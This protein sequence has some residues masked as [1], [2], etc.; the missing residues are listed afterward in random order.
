MEQVKAKHGLPILIPYE[1]NQF[2]E[3]IRKLIREE[4]KEFEIIWRSA[5]Q[6][7]EI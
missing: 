6:K 3:Q 5:R 1:P 2:W 4:I 7:L